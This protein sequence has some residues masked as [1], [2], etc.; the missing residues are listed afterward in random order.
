MKIESLLMHERSEFASLHQ[1]SQ[2]PKDFSVFLAAFITQDGEK[3]EN[4]VQAQAL[5]VNRSKVMGG[6]SGNRN[7]ASSDSGGLKGI[8]QTL[9]SNRV[10]DNVV[11]FPFRFALHVL[12]DLGLFVI[13]HPVGSQFETDSDLVIIGCSGMDLG[14][15]SLGQLKDNMS[16]SSRRG[17]NQDT[18]SLAD[19]CPIY[20][21]VPSGDSN[22]G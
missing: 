13:D 6:T 5:D 20:Q 14:S 21:G 11:A 22:E 12:I 17:M 4:T 10:E 2:L 9:S 19:F 1:A 16:D 15:K 7:H 18:L 8:I 3:H